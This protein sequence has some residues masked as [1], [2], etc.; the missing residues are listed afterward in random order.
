MVYDQEQQ[1]GYSLALHT[2]YQYRCLPISKIIA[3]ISVVHVHQDVHGLP[4][5]PMVAHGPQKML[6][7]ARTS[8]A[9]CCPLHSLSSVSGGH[10]ATGVPAGPGTAGTAARSPSHAGAGIN[11]LVTCS[12]YAPALPGVTENKS[13]WSLHQFNHQSWRKEVDLCNTGK[14]H[15]GD[16]ATSAFLDADTQLSVQLPVITSPMLNK[17]E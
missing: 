11:M 7:C 12:S 10:R 1:R 5:K 14:G 17:G 3:V 4:E 15:T 2:K 6:S 16:N 9:V 13:S 8:Q